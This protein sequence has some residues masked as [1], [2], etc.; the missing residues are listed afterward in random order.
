MTKA[1][2]FLVG[3]QDAVV[4][5]EIARIAQRYIPG[6]EIEIVPGCGHSVYFEK[7]DSFNRILI[8]FFERI[9]T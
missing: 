5:P 6:A 7:P 4:P 1:T 8:D 9:G 2:L 3:E